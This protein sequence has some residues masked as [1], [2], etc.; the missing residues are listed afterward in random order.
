MG[1]W[2]EYLRSGKSVPHWPYPMRYGEE[3]ELSTD[4]LVFGGGIAG[5]H[6]A[7]SAR[8]AGARVLV[9]EKA[10]A[11]WS[12]NGGAGVDHWLSACTNPCSRVSP[13]EYTERVLVDCGGYDCGPL[14]YVA[15]RESWDALLD[16]EGMGVRIRDDK[17]EFA[18]ADF[19]DDATGLLFAYDYIT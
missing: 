3:R 7:I 4:V 18:G 16:V 15:A 19:R 14:R 9:V 5:S 12:G 11:K 1:T 10:A 8:K 13:E 2:H 17:G 6:A